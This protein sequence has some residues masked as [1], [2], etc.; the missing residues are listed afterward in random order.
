MTEILN[1][2]WLGVTRGSCEVQTGHA[3]NSARGF[4]YD[5][6]L[7]L[8]SPRWMLDI[9]LSDRDAAVGGA[10]RAFLARLAFNGGRFRCHDPL[11]RR[12]LAYQFGTTRPWLANPV[13]EASIVSQ[14]LSARTITIGGLAVGAIISPGDACSWAFSGEQRLYRVLESANV[15]ANAS[16]QATFMTG[17]RPRA[18]SNGTAVRFDNAT[19]VF[20]VVGQSPASISLKPGAQ[21]IDVQISAMEVF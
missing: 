11:R 19:S 6:T 7:D 15:I 4:E 8:A 16:G 5:Q 17:P 3:K 18:A 10:L 14:N 21:P 20:E 12:P 1:V 13:V 2:P 9:E